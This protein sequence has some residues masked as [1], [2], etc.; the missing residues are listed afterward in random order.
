MKSKLILAISF[1]TLLIVTLSCTQKDTE[2]KGTIEEENGI[3]VFKNPKEPLYIDYN[4]EFFEDISIGVEEG[5][6]NY[7][8]YD[9]RAI[10]ADSEGNL[11]IL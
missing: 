8:F 9:P 5:D 1:I 6:E 11:Y 4:I 3:T 10:D 2:W 7:M